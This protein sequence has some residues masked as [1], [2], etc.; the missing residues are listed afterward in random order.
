MSQLSHA[1]SKLGKNFNRQVACKSLD[2]CAK[3][4]R[5]PNPDELVINA[6]EAAEILGID[7][8][9]VARLAEVGELPAIRKLP[10][11]TGSWIFDQRIVR[12]V[13]QE[14]LLRKV[15]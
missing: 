15:G 1:P 3:V 6:A 14:R 7:R 11:R 9:T 12:R 8:K 13:A 10:G 4:W 2:A 5:M